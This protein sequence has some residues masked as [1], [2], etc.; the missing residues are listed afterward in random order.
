VAADGPVA[1]VRM[2]GGRRRGAAGGPVCVVSLFDGLFICS[3]VCLFV[4]YILLVSRT[5]SAH[6]VQSML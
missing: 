5:L 1:D 2:G 3:L 4:N 6:G